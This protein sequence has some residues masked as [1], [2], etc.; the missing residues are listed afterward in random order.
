[1]NTDRPEPQFDQAPDP[2]EIRRMIERGSPVD[3]VTREN[4]AR[5]GLVSTPGDR[6][7]KHRRELAKLRNRAA[8]RGR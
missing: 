8:R 3:P 4:L 2:A 6:D 1:M 5:Q 7:A